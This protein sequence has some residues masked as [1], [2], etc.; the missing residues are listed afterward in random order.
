[1]FVRLWLL[2]CMVTALLAPFAAGEVLDKTVPPIWKILPKPRYVQYGGGEDFVPLGRVAV[3]RRENGPYHTRRDASGELVELS[4]VTEEELLV[5]LRERGAQEVVAVSDALEDY[6]DYDALV[7]LGSVR[8]NAIAERYWAEMGLSFESWD[9]ENTEGDAFRDWP[10][11]GTE[12]YVLVVDEVKGQTL[13]V[14]AGYDWDDA[15]DQFYG[16]GTFYALQSFRQL[17]VGQGGDLKVKRATVVDSPLVSFRGCYTGWLPDEEQNWRDVRFL[18]EM[19]ANANI[20]WYGHQ[21]VEYNVEAAS[22]FRYPWR[23]KQL[24]FFGGIGKYCHEHYI[25]PVFCMNPDH[26][27]V[28]WAAPKTFDGSERDPLHYDPNHPVEPEF[29]AMWAEL[30]YEVENDWDILAAKFAQLHKAAPGAMLQVMNE[31]DLFG[32]VHESDKVLFKTNTEDP[33]KNA[34]NYGHA[35]GRFL[36]GLYRRIRALCPGSSLYMPL[37]PP[38]QLAYQLVLNRD[39]ANARDFMRALAET[40]EEEGILKYAPTLTTGGGTAAEVTTAQDLVNFG[41]WYRGGPVQLS[42]NNFSGGYHVGAYETDPEGPRTLYQINDE[43]PAGYRDTT[44]YKRL[45]GFAWNGLSDEHVLAW[46]Q[47]TYMWNMP[48]LEREETNTL[49]TRKVC[50][51][52]TYPS[53]KAFFEE[54]DNPSCYLPDNQ[55]PYRIKFVSDSIAFPTSPDVMHGWQYLMR[56]TDAMRL[57]AQRLRD[58]LHTLLP[59][60]WQKWDNRYEKL[61]SLNSFGHA[62]LSFSN[63][64]LAYGYSRGWENATENEM[65]TGTALRDLYLEAEDV[66]Q[67]VFWGP[68]VVGDVQPVD[69]N[70]YTS[71]LR[72]IYTDGKWE[73]CPTMPSEA[74]IYTDIWTEGL[75]DRFYQL[76]SACALGDVPEGD[77]GLKSG[78]GTAQKQN[79]ET[80]RVVESAASME[81]GPLPAE[82][83]LR[84]RMGTEG[85]PF[86]QS[87]GCRIVIGDHTHKIA[88]CRPRW[89]YIPLAQGVAADA[90]EFE[91]DAPVQVYDVEV[92]SVLGG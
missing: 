38:G 11:L 65:L 62:A 10:D 78:W 28:A 52:E 24:E 57:E 42:Y 41:E 55:P 9:D 17:L 70:H 71:A 21:V 31:D 60:L 81:L 59:E 58:K 63:V 88:V 90:L 82:G 73:A 44:L 25:R 32:L 75:V 40:L 54:F 22:K 4:T 72:F 16:A 5:L 68:H 6:S 50:T 34:T 51:E 64:Y 3:V 19:K 30:G 1:M 48:A 79:G 20:Y 77:A 86:T 91:T 23:D 43:Y 66:Q 53:V 39:E 12:G 46:C 92:Y 18:S 35:R 7:L 87:T 69:T 15:L 67:C 76:A 27:E 2:G 89:F 8:F 13:I 36:A 83:L 74:E 47:S 29:K 14:L 45:W 84:V 56:Y 61:A 49:A 33:R 26:Y 80:F 85:T 37:C